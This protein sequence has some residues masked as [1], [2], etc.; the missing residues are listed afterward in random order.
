E[1]LFQRSP[2]H[3]TSHSQAPFDHATSYA[4]LARSGRVGLIAF[5]LGQGYYNQGF[6]VYRQAFQKVLDEVLPVRLIHTDAHL[7]TELSLTHQAVE[8]RAGRKEHY[9]VHIVNY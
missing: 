6:W 1:P 7:S 8:P 5:P 3:Y 4:A 2:E 9:L